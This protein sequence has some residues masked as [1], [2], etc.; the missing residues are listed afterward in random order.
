MTSTPI[1]KSDAAELLSALNNTKFKASERW[2]AERH[3]K[4]VISSGPKDDHV[5]HT[6][7]MNWSILYGPSPGKRTFDD[8]SMRL[9]SVLTKIIKGINPN[10]YFCSVHINKNFPGT[11]HV[12]GLNCGP[13]IMITVGENVSGG[14]LWL[15]GK[16]IKTLNRM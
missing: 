12:D 13:S 4:V 8:D 3:G 11:L 10:F 2:S 16:V 6:I 14:D 5:C 9:L 1:S 15:N 7:G